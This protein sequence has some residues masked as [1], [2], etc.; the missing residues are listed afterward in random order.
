MENKRKMSRTKLLIYVAAAVLTILLVCWVLFGSG[1]FWNGPKSNN[2]V[3]RGPFLDFVRDTVDKNKDGEITKE[4][5]ESVREMC[6]A[7]DHVG[8]GPFLESPEGKTRI[9]NPDGTITFKEGTFQWD[10]EWLSY[11]PNLEVLYLVGCGIEELDLSKNPELEALVCSGNELK[12]LDISANLQ[13]MM[14]LCDENRLEQLILSSDETYSEMIFLD[15][16]CNRLSELDLSRMPQLSYL[17]CEINQLSSL[18]VSNNLHLTYLNTS[19]NRIKDVDISK[20]PNLNAF[21]N[22]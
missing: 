5:Y 3:F 16:A 6:F 7:S 20:C 14:V 15:V 18:D 2:N 17:R 12:K 1:Y 19:G 21:V 9:P 8:N 10:S 11:F 13:L 22:D 4:E